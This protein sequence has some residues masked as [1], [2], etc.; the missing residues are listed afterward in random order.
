MVIILIAVVA[1]LFLPQIWASRIMA[2][3]NYQ[4]TDIPGTGGQFAKHLITNLNLEG[5]EVTEDK[6]GLGDHY[7]P[8]N[9]TVALSKKNFESKSL[10]ALVVASHEIGH[11]YQDKTGYKPLELRTKL[12]VFAG[13]AEKIASLILFASPLITFLTKMPI[14]GAIVFVSAFGVMILPVL[15]HLVTLPTEFDA[16]FKRAL[17]ILST[18][19]LKD[20]DLKIARKIL[21]ACSL[22]YVA[23]SMA[24]LLNLWRWLR[25]LRR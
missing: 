9:K 16:S 10:T 5:C 22:T 18:G 24:G 11:A 21:F 4:R 1:F 6:T 3:Y 14:L 15:I 23:A 19:Y 25:L 17:P 20:D 2:K 12:I 8:G 7:D 13:I